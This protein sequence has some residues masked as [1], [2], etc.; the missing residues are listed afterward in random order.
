MRRL[1][2]RVRIDGPDD[3]LPVVLEPGL[4]ASSVG[5]SGLHARLAESSR[6]ISYDRA[7][8]GASP[9]SPGHRDLT[10]LTADLA[11]VIATAGAGPAVLV[12][13][14]LGATIARYLA[15]RRPDLVAGLVLVDPIPD[16]WV[17]RHARWARPAGALM[18][19]A[20]QTTAHI[21]LMDALTALPLGRAIVRSSTSPLA[22]LTDDERD[23]LAAEMRRPAHHRTARREFT[24]LLNSRAELRTLATHRPAVP[25]TILSGTRTHPL[26]KPLRAR[27]TDW[28][29]WLAESGRHVVVPDGDHFIPRCRPEIVCAEVAE[30]RARTSR[31]A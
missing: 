16:A 19:L 28:H 31:T 23:Q 5:W 12:G 20:M 15:H 26:A 27:A 18:Y 29:A 21:G 9:P 8:L 13:H 14:S 7:G 22:A 24:G 11:E 6:V 10:A 3:A 2:V 4:G 25:L 17:L 30:L 1:P